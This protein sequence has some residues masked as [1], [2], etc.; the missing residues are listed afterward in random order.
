MAL[1]E[2]GWARRERA[3]FDASPPALVALA[4]LP[5]MA[6]VWV[7]LSPDLVLSHE[8]TWDFLYNLSGAWQLQTGHTA[9]LDF[10]DP[11]GTLTFRLTWLGF[12]LLGPTP[13][14]FLAGSAR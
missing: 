6:A 13:F 14:A 7:L 12:A 8:M 5:V 4:S 10:H 1:A 11:L 9:H 3:G 2:G